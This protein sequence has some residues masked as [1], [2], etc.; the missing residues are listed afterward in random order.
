M[1]TSSSVLLIGSVVIIGIVMPHLTR[2]ILKTR[3]YKLVTP[4][5]GLL[6]SIVI[7]FGM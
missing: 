1:V 3:N 5:S 7:M 2:I 6:S 4:I